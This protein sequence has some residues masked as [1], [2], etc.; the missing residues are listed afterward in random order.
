MVIKDKEK[1]SP[2][3]QASLAVPEDA[4]E[5]MIN[6]GGGVASVSAPLVRPATKEELQAC[7]SLR[8]PRSFVARLDALRKQK[9][10]IPSRNQTIIE[11]LEKEFEN[12]KV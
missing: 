8:V 11:I 12:A 4:I 9:D 1:K 5:R 6:K 10:V 3:I 2:T 7:F